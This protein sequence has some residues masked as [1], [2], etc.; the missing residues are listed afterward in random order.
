MALTLKWSM[1]PH[2]IMRLAL[3]VIPCIAEAQ[4]PSGEI[5][6]TVD[7]SIHHRALRGAIVIAT[8]AAVVVDSSFH[9]A[10]T[11]S[12]GAFTI[13][14]LRGGRYVVTIEHPY[15]DSTR[16]GPPPVELALTGSGSRQI[17]IG[18]PSAA[19]LRQ[20]F[21]PALS[22]DS[23][24]G[25][26]VGAIQHVDGTPVSYGSVVFQWTEFEVDRT[27]MAIR[28][29]RHS[30]RARAD[31]LGIYRAC[32]LPVGRSL[33]IQAQ[34]EET[35]YSGVIEEEIDETPILV[36]DFTI[37]R[38]TADAGL[39]NTL[40]VVGT[41]MTVSSRPIVSARVRLIGTGEEAL[42]D[43]AGTFRLPGVHFGTE[44][45]EIMALGYIPRRIRMNVGK[46]SMP[47]LIQLQPFARVLDSVHV[48]GSAVNPRREF[49]QRMRSGL[50]R[51][52]TEEE[53]A[54]QHPFETTDLF[55]MLPHYSVE[56]PGG[57]NDAVIVSNHGS[58]LGHK[59][60]MQVFVDGNPVKSIDANTV[61][62]NAI[63]GIEV[64]DLLEAPAKYGAKDC[65]IVLIWSR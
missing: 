7:D 55:R 49:D 58:F 42:T 25:G 26:A 13:A 34:G 54:E 53:I 38:R 4:V 18:T 19:T 1:K 28:E 39:G 11:D 9:V 21:C 59:C 63:H 52:V 62:P 65:G 47:V 16:L 32:G 50:G 33:L 24:Y 12:G 64:Y 5:T 43:S 40:A 56:H 22:T 51:Y 15:F 44:G 35:E 45:I 29:Q 14:G 27:A 30:S 41:V 8:P 20:R 37:P 10:V 57:S 2:A 61:S 17:E 3:V 6:G 46:G 23:T 36:R 48:V 31:S 60:V